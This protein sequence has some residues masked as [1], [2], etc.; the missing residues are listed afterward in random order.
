M[1]PHNN[2]KLLK[3]Y[4]RRWK[5]FQAI[6]II[7]YRCTCYFHPQCTIPMNS[8]SAGKSWVQQ[9]YNSRICM[10]SISLMRCWHKNQYKSVILK[11]V[12]AQNL[13]R[14]SCLSVKMC[15]SLRW[16]HATA[17]T[18]HFQKLQ[19]VFRQKCY[20]TRNLHIPQLH[21]FEDYQFQD[22]TA[23]HEFLLIKNMKCALFHRELIR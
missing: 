8:C 15:S 10:Q 7:A 11:K 12:L 23:L 13:H 20:I 1:T 18:H 3:L 17:D 2:I 9:D 4:S 21:A 5:F 22:H 14:I 19:N 6:N 16:R